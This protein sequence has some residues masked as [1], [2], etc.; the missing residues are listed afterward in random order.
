MKL[1]DLITPQELFAELEALL[2][3]TPGHEDACDKGIADVESFDWGNGLGKH[4]S[5]RHYPGCMLAIVAINEALKRKAATNA[6]QTPAGQQT[7]LRGGLRS[8]L[9]GSGST[10]KEP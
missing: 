7:D 4:L 3:K 1:I 6:T 8:G 10:A 2:D 9:E 5:V